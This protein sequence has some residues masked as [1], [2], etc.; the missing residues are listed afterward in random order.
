MC[1]TLVVHACTT[2]V[3]F[4]I[5]TIGAN[6][7]CHLLCLI[8]TFFSPISKKMKE[9]LRLIPIGDALSDKGP[10]SDPESDS[11]SSTDSNAHGRDEISYM[12]HFV[13]EDAL[14]CAT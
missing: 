1:F 10:L 14:V 2:M 12:L 6:K 13:D 7:I 11:T 5:R 4:S 9:F 3:R 8:M